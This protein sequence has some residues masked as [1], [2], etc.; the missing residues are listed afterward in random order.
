MEF[1]DLIIIGAG[2][3]GLTAAIFAKRMGIDVAIVTK[4]VGGQAVL[5]EKIENYPGFMSISGKELISKM[6]AQVSNLGVPII[7]DEVISIE[8]NGSKF[9]VEGKFC[10]LVGKAV[11]IACGK[12]PKKLGVEREEEFVGKGISYCLLCDLP[13]FKDK[14]VGIIG[15]S[16]LMVPWITEA[17]KVAAKVYAFF[18]GRVEEEIETK[19]CHMEIYENGKVRKLFGDERLESVEIEH[20]VDGVKKVERIKLDCLFVQRGFIVETSWLKNFIKLDENGQIIIDELCRTF[21]PEGNVKKGVFAAGD[22]T[23]IPFKQIIVACGEGAK[24][25]LEAVRYLKKG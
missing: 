5:A 12:S 19:G 15:P 13:L 8:E 21:S 3:A 24:A 7:F 11:I 14:E 23:S 9:V 18:E 16:T 20:E 2:P 25:S 10:K 22:A 6:Y 17:C 4:D 1:H